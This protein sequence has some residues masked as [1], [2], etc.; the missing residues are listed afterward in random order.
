MLKLNSK[1]R[2]A[3]KTIR[4]ARKANKIV[5][6]KTT[7]NKLVKKKRTPSALK[8]ILTF[9]KPKR[10]KRKLATKSLTRSFKKSIARQKFQLAAKR[11][12]R[13]ELLIKLKEKKSAM[14]GNFNLD[15][16]QKLKI[17]I[18]VAKIA[19]TR[20]SKAIIKKSTAITSKKIIMKFL[21]GPQLKVKRTK[22][23]LKVAK[24]AVKKV[25]VRLTKLR[26]V[27]RKRQRVIRSKMNIIHRMIIEK[28]SITDIKTVRHQVRKIQRKVSKVQ[29]KRKLEKLMLKA[30][31][32]KIAKQ[33][34][35]VIRARAQVRKVV[36]LAAQAKPTSRRVV[37][38][39]VVKIQRKK[40]TKAK[41]SMAAKLET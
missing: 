28:K 15:Q 8:S 24:R 20:V 25:R 9:N 41:K 32:A 13:K 18:Q 19:F 5:V 7:L 26:K 12:Q 27:V 21:R 14:K 23:I 37:K 4:V 38:L 34:K 10:S 40:L 35:S 17:S 6:R 16:V 29:G 22:K 30:T 39:R 31:K 11:I 3:K 1:I 33:K 2:Q 36:T